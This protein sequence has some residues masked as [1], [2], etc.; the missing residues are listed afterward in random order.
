MN[1]FIGRIT[2]FISAYLIISSIVSMFTPYHW[3]NPW[4]S[5]KVQFL[6]KADDH[7]Y[8]TFFFG[9]SLV[10]RQIDPYVF[11]ST[12]NSHEKKTSHSFNLGAPATFNPQSY[13]LYD[14]FLKSPAS[15]NTKYCFIELR[16]VDLFNDYFLHQ[17]RATYW[18]NYPDLKFIFN[19]IYSNPNLKAKRKLHS[20]RNYSISYL[21]K[22]FHLGHFGQQIN[23]PSYY[24]DD[25]VG[26]SGFF[27]LEVE[28]TSTRDPRVKN[29]L[30]SRKK[31][32]IMDSSLVS[33]RKR[34]I[35]EEYADTRE[36]FDD[37]HL[38]R[39]NEMIEES[40]DKGI[41]L[42]FIIS[43]RYANREILNLSSRILSNHVID[44][45]N[46]GKF[47]SLY[48]LENSF[49]VSHLNTKG[50]REYTRLLAEEFLK[51]KERA[52]NRV[53]GPD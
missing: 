43:P 21:E 37:L 15:K 10:Y 14:H 41:H 34:R 40:I 29:S 47:S 42:T 44:M 49:D 38:K 13:Y 33:K 52:H 50:A 22:I 27:P 4:F 6:N 28:L 36:Y 31:A 24:S 3:G 5:S 25:Y 12:L 32:I 20:Y 48:D 2:L 46:P 16:D 8:N 30:Q 19:S 53:D 45:A 7:N 39:I 26:V 17:E 9:S 51:I 11:D 23:S 1:K 18:Q 35:I